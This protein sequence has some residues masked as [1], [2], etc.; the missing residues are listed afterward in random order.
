VVHSQEAIT[1]VIVLEGGWEPVAVPPPTYT[2]KPKADRSAE[3]AALLEADSDSAPSCEPAEPVQ[4]AIALDEL[5]LD[6]V[7]E[8]RRAAGE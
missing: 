5:D 7:L 1:E 6:L 8:R 4:P 2:M 3:A